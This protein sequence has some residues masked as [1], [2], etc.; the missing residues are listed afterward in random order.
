MSTG[1][2]I[3]YLVK[4]PSSALTDKLKIAFHGKP[5]KGKVNVSLR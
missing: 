4:D 5:V 2:A 1:A 3:R